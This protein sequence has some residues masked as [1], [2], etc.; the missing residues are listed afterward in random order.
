MVIWPDFCSFP[1]QDLTSLYVA[2]K[3]QLAL[4]TQC[5]LLSQREQE[6][7]WFFNQSYFF[8]NNFFCISNLSIYY[9]LSIILILL[10]IVTIYYILSFVTS[11]FLLS[12]KYFLLFLISKAVQPSKYQYFNDYVNCFEVKTHT[13]DTY[14]LKH[15]FERTK[16]QGIS[17]L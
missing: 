17:V 14:T 1:R 2:T 7:F 4:S 6:L 16:N 12:Y 3:L 15:I 8:L 5:S 9:I 13:H 10:N 11:C